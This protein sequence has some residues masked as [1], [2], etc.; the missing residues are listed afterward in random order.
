MATMMNEALQMVWDWGQ[1]HGLVF[2]PT[3][4]VVCMFEP[5]RRY[6]HEPIVRMG[7]EE[8][9]YSKVVKYL[10]ITLDKRLSWA[11]HV[12]GRI[13]KCSYLLNKLSRTVGREWGFSPNRIKWVYTAVIK[14]K[15]MYGSMVWSHAVT[16]TSN[17]R[18]D[19]LQRKAL[20]HM[21]GPSFKS[22][23]TAGMEVMLGLPPLSL[24]IK[25][26]AL[27]SASRLGRP[28]MSW[29][30]FGSKIARKGH[31]KSNWD[32][33]D[34]IE[35]VD[36]P[37]DTISPKLNWLENKKV[38]LPEV[39]IYTDGSRIDNIAGCAFAAS[40]GDAIIAEEIIPLG[41]VTVF[42][43]EL[44]AIQ[45]ALLWLKNNSKQCKRCWIKSDSQ[46][47]IGAIFARYV[48]SKLVMEI[49]HNLA[50]LRQQGY[51][52]EISW[53]KGHANY[54]GN[55]YV[56]CLAKQGVEMFRDTSTLCPSIPISN[57]IIKR[58]IREAIDKKWDLRWRN[59]SQ[60]SKTKQ[61]LPS[62]DRSRQRL[63]KE[64]SRNSLALLTQ[65]VTG[66]GNFRAHMW[67]MYPEDVDLMCQ[68]C[69]EQPETP[70]HI[71]N[72]PH[73]SFQRQNEDDETEFQP[74]RLLQFFKGSIVPSIMESNRLELEKL[75]DK[76]KK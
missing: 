70:W 4:T 68:I 10:G 53:I 27:N 65:V 38:D 37:S 9:V 21:V 7:G 25:E 22:T 29:T 73:I 18:L 76:Y 40:K 62:V 51:E 15:L 1:S 46:S 24:S 34:S 69:G 45:H 63:I 19:R 74:R 50:E 17:K 75:I 14:P 5:D 67:Y 56:D 66:H 3:K 11:Q 20:N 64:F 57:K 39:I 72:C 55:E 12:E 35:E 52:I 49:G 60:C 32:E 41:D 30:G 26:D 16:P 8:L 31:L 44:I 6:K 48:T 59:N 58:R 47:G 2:N 61:F 54:T 13:N 23:P 28:K 42:N 36:F 71:Y 43:A 33:L